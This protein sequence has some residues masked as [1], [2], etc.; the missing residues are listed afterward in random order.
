MMHK[1]FSK[2]ENK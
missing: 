2:G 1:V